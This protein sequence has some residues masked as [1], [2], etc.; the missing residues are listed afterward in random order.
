MHIGIGHRSLGRHRR[1]GDIGDYIGR[2]QGTRK[3]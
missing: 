3:L 1:L 2:A